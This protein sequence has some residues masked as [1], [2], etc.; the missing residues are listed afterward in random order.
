M[1]QKLFFPNLPRAEPHLRDSTAI[2]R[3]MECPRKYFYSMVLGYKSDKPYPYFTFGNA[4]HKFR[5]VLEI[6]WMEDP[7]ISNAPEYVMNALDRALKFFDKHHVPPP[8]GNK[9]EFMNKD[10]IIKSCLKSAEHWKQEKKAGAIVV[11]AIEQPFQITLDDG[12][13]I[14]GRFD[15]VIN[16]RGKVRG[17]DFKTSSI[18]G[19]YYINTLNPNDQFTRYTYAENKLAGWDETDVNDKM[20]VDGQIIEVLFNTKTQGPTIEAFPAL[21]TRNEI[22][23]WLAEQRYWHKIMAEC[24]ASDI[25]PMNTRSCTYCEFRPV[26]KMSSE[27][28]QQSKLKHSYNHE[29]WDCTHSTKEEE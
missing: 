21:R 8:K 5:E 12:E 17:R 1:T 2:T 19:S 28:H 26:C 29:P 27:S 3:F 11:M 18:S 25:W 14:A 16:M 4:Y 23:Q 15:Q 10:R 9:F 20:P 13:V 7:L 6:H 24:R 22:L